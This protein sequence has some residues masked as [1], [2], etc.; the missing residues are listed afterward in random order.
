[1]L[2]LLDRSR[3]DV[4]GQ[5]AHLGLHPGAGALLL[6]VDDGEHCTERHRGDLATTLIL[7]DIPLARGARLRA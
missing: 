3:M 4:V 2:E 5:Y 1:M 7:S 6:C